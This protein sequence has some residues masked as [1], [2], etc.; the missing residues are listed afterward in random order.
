[1]IPL[2]NMVFKNK[3]RSHKTENL[4]PRLASVI[5]DLSISLMYDQRG[6]HGYSQA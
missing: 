5:R 1:M 6:T 2:S 4:S 3:E